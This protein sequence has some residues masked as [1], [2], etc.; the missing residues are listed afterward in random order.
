VSRTTSASRH[1]L[2]KIAIFPGMAAHCS[3]S[4]K[5]LTSAASVMTNGFSKRDFVFVIWSL[6]SAHVSNTFK[7]W[8]TVS[9]AVKGTMLF[10]SLLA[11]AFCRPR[12]CL[13]FCS[14]ACFAFLSAFAFSA[15][16]ARSAFCSRRARS[17]L[18]LSKSSHETATADANSPKSG[19]AEEILAKL[20]FSVSSSGAFF[21]SHD[22]RCSSRTERTSSIALKGRKD[23]APTFSPIFLANSSDSA[24]LAG[25]KA[26]VNL[27]PGSLSMAPSRMNSARPSRSL[28]MSS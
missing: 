18:A 23:S 3:L 19:I 12:A 11:W 21:S 1:L 2:P 13:F 10:T 9:G 16:A 8:P 17:F 6:A 14:S 26:T 24:S 27:L 25:R 5:S 7:G 4:K 28:M 22:K 20:V 15:F